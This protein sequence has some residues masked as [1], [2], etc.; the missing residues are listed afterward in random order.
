MKENYSF[1][2]WL[3]CLLKFRV[4]GLVP[5]KQSQGSFLGNE[6]YIKIP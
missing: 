4:R 5:L 3:K 6:N 2:F 1:F